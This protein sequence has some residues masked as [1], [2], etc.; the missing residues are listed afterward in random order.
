MRG[1]PIIIFPLG[2]AKEGLQCLL[3]SV[4]KSQLNQ[5]LHSDIKNEDKGA[6]VWLS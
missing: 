4:C 5:S 1:S 3:M 2:F 6:P